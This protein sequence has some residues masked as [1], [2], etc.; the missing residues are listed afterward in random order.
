MPE[1]FH[2]LRPRKAKSII[3]TLAHQ[4]LYHVGG[5]NSLAWFPMSHSHNT[6]T[7]PLSPRHAP[8]W[9]ARAHPNFFL[10]PLSY[11]LISLTVRT[12]DQPVAPQG[13]SPG[14][15]FVIS[16]ALQ[17]PGHRVI[18]SFNLLFLP[19]LSFREKNSRMIHFEFKILRTMVEQLVI[20]I[21]WINEPS[22]KLLCIVA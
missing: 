8:L 10:C 20:T 4:A 1:G 15:V 22:F 9:G 6:E 18:N 3:L 19:R 16:C 17:G 2:C 21:E 5:T 11:L 7:L 13:S 14:L 12:A